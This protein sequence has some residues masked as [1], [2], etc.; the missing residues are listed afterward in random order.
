M[1][2]AV[3]EV[4]GP[5]RSSLQDI[6]LNDAHIPFRTR[7]T[8]RHAKAAPRRDR[9]H[10]SVPGFD[11]RPG[12]FFL[13]AY[14]Q[15]INVDTGLCEPVENYFAVAAVGRQDRA[16]SMALGEVLARCFSGIVLTVEG[17]AS[18]LTYKISE[19][20]GSFVPVLAHKRR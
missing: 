1:A 14:R 6:L 10:Q 16:Q 19:T 20:D 8:G 5:R 7:L 9:A 15:F 2:L 17:A 4:G 18:A 12:A 3:V 13:K 11:E